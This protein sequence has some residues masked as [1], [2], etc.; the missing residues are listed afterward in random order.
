MPSLRII[1]VLPVP[2]STKLRI[3]H[4]L[5]YLK[6]TNKHILKK[7][8]RKLVENRIHNVDQAVSVFFEDSDT[9]DLFSQNHLRLNLHCCQDE[10]S[11]IISVATSVIS[12][13]TYFEEIKRTEN[14][15]HSFVHTCETV[16]IS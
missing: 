1:V 13:Y 12:F 7:T 3:L 10:R 11:D 8:E 9:S 6:C 4:L 5:R 2:V 16:L 14:T 15:V